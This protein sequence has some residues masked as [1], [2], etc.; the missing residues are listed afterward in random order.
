MICIQIKHAYKAIKNNKNWFVA[1]FAWLTGQA[2]K[3]LE[4]NLAKELKQN[5]SQRGI[6][7]DIKIKDKNGK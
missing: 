5:L 6:E 2:K 3:E 4:K 7:I 1:A